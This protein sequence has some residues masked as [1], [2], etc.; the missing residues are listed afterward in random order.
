MSLSGIRER[1]EREFAA[2]R[3]ELRKIES[4]VEAARRDAKS[5]RDANERLRR[6]HALLR[7]IEWHGAGGASGSR[8][9]GHCPSC[10]GTEPKHAAGCELAGVLGDVSE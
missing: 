3:A 8:A 10:H 9:K 1:M 2:V 7:E 4:A 5:S 6:A